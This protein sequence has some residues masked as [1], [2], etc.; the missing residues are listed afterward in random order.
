MKTTKSIKKVKI[1]GNRVIIDFVL[2]TETDDSRIL[3][4]FHTVDSEIRPHEDFSKAFQDLKVHGIRV[5]ELTVFMEKMDQKI[6]DKHKVT[7]LTF[8]ENDEATQ[9]VISLNKE[10]GNGKVFSVSTPLINLYED[11]YYGQ[12]QMAEDVDKVIMEAM[13]YI[14]GKN[15][16]KQLEIRFAA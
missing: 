16:E 4:S 7:T 8:S 10:I 1:K 14:E 13:K 12:E 6:L 3:N 15:G 5:C 2:H 9:V 11:E